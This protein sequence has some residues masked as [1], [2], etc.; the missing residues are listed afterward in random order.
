MTVGRGGPQHFL[1]KMSP[2]KDVLLR[3]LSG[4]S[5][6]MV[7]ARRFI[8]APGTINLQRRIE[9]THFDQKNSIGGLMNLPFFQMAASHTYDIAFNFG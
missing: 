4:Y 6:P 2:L 5:I 8:I 3:T 9:L 7:A 1:I